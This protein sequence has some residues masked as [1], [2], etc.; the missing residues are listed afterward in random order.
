HDDSALVSS[1]S[2]ASCADSGVPQTETVTPSPVDRDLDPSEK[3]R[4][5]YNLY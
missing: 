1:E 2:E 5:L 4:T 3:V